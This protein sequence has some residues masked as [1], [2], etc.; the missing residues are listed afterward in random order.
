MFKKFVSMYGV[1]QAIRLAFH[2]VLTKV[3]FYRS[4]LIRLPYYIRGRSYID[5]GKGLTTGV[6]LRVD[7]FKVDGKND[8]KLKIGNDC[9]FNDYVHI[10]CI[11]SVSIGNEVLIASKVFITDHNHGDLQSISDFSLTPKSRK[12]ASKPVVIEDRVWLGEGV[13]VLPGVK[14]GEGSVIGAASVVTKEVPSY[15][16]AVGVPAR[17]IKRLNKEKSTWEYT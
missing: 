14:I 3:F 9:E 12:L 2:L 5:F 11:D 8:P 15:S 17:V 7:A 4:R 6:G 1:F 13:M 10:G 16:V